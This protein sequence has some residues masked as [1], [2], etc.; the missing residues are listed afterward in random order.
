MRADDR[1]E[2]VRVHEEEVVVGEHMLVQVEGHVDAES[3]ANDSDVYH[4]PDSDSEVV[5]VGSIDV[6]AKEVDSSMDDCD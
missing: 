1:V 5:E 6:D 4:I 3:N 2:E